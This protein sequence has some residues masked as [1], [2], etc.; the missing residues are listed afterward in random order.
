MSIDFDHEEIGTL[1]ALALREDIGPGDATCEAVIPADA[2]GKTAVVAREE[3]VYCGTP[4]VERVVAGIDPALQV[5]ALA[6][7]GAVL[8]PGDAAL[9]LEGPL[10]GMLTAERTFL[11]FLLRMS[12]V[13][14]MTRRFVDAVAGF[15]VQILDTRKTTPGF[16]Q[17]EKYAV[18]CGGGT[19]HRMGLYDRV[20]LKDNHLAGRHADT[21]AGLVEAV[22][23]ARSAKPDLVIEVEADSVAQ[24][25]ALVG[26]E[27]DWILLDNMDNDTLRTCVALCAGRC[28]TEASGGVNLSTV[29][30]IAETGVDAISVGALTHSAPAVDLGLDWRG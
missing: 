25:E 2:V 12:G 21:A 24:V 17:L 10:A 16:R 29:R 18:V 28:K 1:I 6:E 27:P 26:A 22:H 9:E 30:G 23:T 7:E 4:V 5:T 20:M 11:N 3:L 19:N 8:Q 13:A 14:T 15:P